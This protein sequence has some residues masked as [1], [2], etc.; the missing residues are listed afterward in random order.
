MSMKKIIFGILV[1]MLLVTSVPAEAANITVRNRTGYT[2]HYLYI[3]PTGSN[4]W[5]QDLLGSNVLLN[6]Y[7]YTVSGQS[8]ARYDIRMVDE[9]GDSYTRWNVGLNEGTG[10]WWIE[11][12]MDHIDR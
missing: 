7:E 3:S 1:L 2:G 5:G 10:D 4:Q 12:S 11:L 6:G 8:G 9:D